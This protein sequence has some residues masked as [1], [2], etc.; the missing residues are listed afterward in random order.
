MAMD[1]RTIEPKLK[2]CIE[3]LKSLHSKL[4]AQDKSS[5]LYG[6]AALFAN[7]YDRICLWAHDVKVWD[8]VLD[9]QLRMSSSLRDCIWELLSDL[10]EQHD[11]VPSETTIESTLEEVTDIVDNL[12]S[13]GPALRSP[14][15]LDQ[16]LTKIPE[17]LTARLPTSTE[18]S[19]GII[20]ATERL[21][22]TNNK[23]DLDIVVVP[24]PII[25]ESTWSAA[26]NSFTRLLPDVLE[27]NGVHA[28][29]MSF[30][31]TL[32]YLS[33]KLVDDETLD[34]VVNKLVQDLNKARYGDPERPLFFIGLSLGGILAKGAISTIISE[35]LIVNIERPVCGCMF[36]AV[37]HDIERARIELWLS[38]VFGADI[39]PDYAKPLIR[40]NDAFARDALRHKIDVSSFYTANENISTIVPLPNTEDA[41]SRLMQST[42]I[43][44]DRETILPMAH[45]I[46]RIAEPFVSIQQEEHE[47]IYSGQM[48]SAKSGSRQNEDPFAMLVA[49]DTAILVNDSSTASAP[50]WASFVE[51]VR[52]C[53]D[54]VIGYRD[55]ID[56]QLYTSKRTRFSVTES[57][58]ASRILADL[59]PP[60]IPWDLAAHLL[61]YLRGYRSSPSSILPDGSLRPCNLIILTA[62]APTQTVDALL[63][64]ISTAVDR[65]SPTVNDS[66]QL[67]IQF[68]LLGTDDAATAFFDQLDLA[69]RQQTSS[70]RQ[71]RASFSPF[72]L[73]RR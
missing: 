27:E 41:T 49:Y 37:P 51:I 64:I 19:H 36:I 65:P 42:F 48:L 28:R 69:T 18:L 73:T 43:P 71:G 30:G 61:R 72:A 3:G 20:V 4:S 57:A 29:I 44:M 46:A 45:A 32:K 58:K 67:C 11:V 9:K 2:I 38:T 31:Y 23:A 35:G 14:A 25:K 21:R 6:Y 22:F 16:F 39:S 66:L 50:V 40:F 17:V 5:A 62:H 68:V 8:S 15:P 1:S 34:P 13:L 63:K 7:Q 70:A 60:G 55:D 33:I 24:G 10:A 47:L 59:K 54:I 12:I 53:V 52:D 26:L 56:L